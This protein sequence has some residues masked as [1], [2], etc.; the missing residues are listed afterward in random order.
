MADNLDQLK[1]ALKTR[2]DLGTF[3]L[4]AGAGGM[5]DAIWNVAAFFEP[6]TFGPL[7]GAM[8]LGL[9]KLVIDRKKPDAT[10]DR[11]P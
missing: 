1:L 10:L 3:L 8:A 6:I 5:A 7:C 2:T 11:D 4:V 9:K